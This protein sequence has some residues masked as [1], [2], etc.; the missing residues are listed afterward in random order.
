[1]GL[2]LLEVAFDVL[3]L[4]LVMFL[5]VE[6]GKANSKRSAIHWLFVI[7]GFIL[8]N[9]TL[10]ITD[11][12][13]IIVV[14]HTDIDFLPVDGIDGV[15]GLVFLTLLMNSIIL[16]VTNVE[17]IFI[18]M[19]G[20]I[21][22]F[23]L[24]LFSVA[25]IDIVSIN[26]WLIRP[27]TLILALCF[28]WLVKKRLVNYIRHDF[29][30]FVKFVLVSVFAFLMYMIL[31]TRNQNGL[32]IQPVFMI[33]V[34]FILFVLLGWLFYEQK[35]TQ[36]MENRMKAIENYIPIIDELVMEV[37]SRQHEF[38]NKL[39]AISSILHSSDN[40]KDAQKQVSKYVDNVQLTSGQYELLNMDHKVIAGFLYTKMKRAEQLN[41]KLMIER[42]VS[43]SEFPCEDYDLIEV[44]GILIDN[45]IEAC[46][47]GDTIIIRMRKVNNHHEL[48][49][50]NPAEYMTNEQFME[51]FK[52]G[53]STKSTFSNERGFG[54]FNVQQIAK[55][56]N[57]KIIAR[58]EQKEKMITIGIQF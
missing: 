36:V 26:Q 24:R 37:R 34:V 14:P 1:M 4:F 57:G 27:L 38:S 13:N 8:V 50:S 53:Y 6:R 52:L 9:Q 46:Y 3:S 23:L 58:N 29:S 17:I 48:T 28:Y 45:A 18:T 30:H 47:G 42:T 54:L 19:F 44:L 49:V 25:I 39:L 10:V 35:K 41:I 43:V 7:F 11:G 40:I 56:Y 51:L 22:W 55:Q 32:I 5:V 33:F 16:K 31:I 12:S 20:F 2:L 15:L 21:V